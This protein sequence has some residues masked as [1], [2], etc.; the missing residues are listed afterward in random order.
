[1][2]HANEEI[3]NWTGFAIRISFGVKRA[4]WEKQATHEELPATFLRQTLQLLTGFWSLNLFASRSSL[5]LKQESIGL[6]WRE[7]KLP[8]SP[9]LV[10]RILRRKY[11]SSSRVFNYKRFNFTFSSCYHQNL[12]LSPFF[13]GEAT[14]IFPSHLS[15]SINI[16]YS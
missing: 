10:L 15:L 2:V 3:S 13:W 6:T 7:G 8:S 16:S 14:L 5:Q 11:F 4:W 1:M 12:L 9:W